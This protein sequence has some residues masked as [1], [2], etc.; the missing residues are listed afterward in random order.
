MVAQQHAE[1]RLGGKHVGGKVIDGAEQHFGLGGGVLTHLFNVVRDFG[2]QTLHL[3]HHEIR[4]ERPS[5]PQQIGALGR[6]NRLVPDG[7]G[8]TPFGA[9]NLILYR[10]SGK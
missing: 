10:G 4:H 2:K 6:F 3:A 7:T 8:L 5:F 9:F 1:D